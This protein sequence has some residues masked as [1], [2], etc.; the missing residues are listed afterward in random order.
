[1]KVVYDERTGNIISAIGDDQDPLR[2]YRD[3]SEEF[4]GNLACISVKTVPNPLRNYYVKDEKLMKYTEQ[5]IREKQLYGRILTK[6]ERQLE[7][8]KPSHEEVKKAENTIEILTLIQEV[9]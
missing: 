9:M 2:Y 5:E 6:E 3:L 4:K 1:M 7:K 8:L